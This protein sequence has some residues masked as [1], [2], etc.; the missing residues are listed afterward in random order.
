MQMTSTIPFSVPPS[1]VRA[2]A[3]TR[4]TTSQSQKPVR[5]LPEAVPVHRPQR[6]KVRSMFRPPMPVKGE[7]S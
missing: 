6:A 3:P 1:P 5:S 7:I 2:I 4:R